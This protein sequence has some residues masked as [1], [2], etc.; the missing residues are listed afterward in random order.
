MNASGS[1]WRVTR[2]GAPLRDFSAT[3]LT[4]PAHD[5]ARISMANPTTAPGALGTSAPSFDLPGTDGKR[6]SLASVLGR[7]GTVV[8]F[9]CN[10]CPYVKAVVDKIVCDMG[11]LAQHGVG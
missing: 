10:H 6:H 8:M 1:V 7:N 2:I 4:H 9:I 3:I 11:E 5:E